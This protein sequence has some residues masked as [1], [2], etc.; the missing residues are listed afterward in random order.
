[1]ANVQI[2]IPAFDE[3]KQV[4]FEIVGKTPLMM[5]NPAS[6]LKPVGPKPVQQRIPKAEDEAAAAAYKNDDGTFYFPADAFR[7]AIVKAGKG[8]KA[9]RAGVAGLAMAGVFPVDEHVQL[10]D[11]ETGKPLR[12]YEIDV[13]RAVPPG[14]GAVSRARPKLP[15]WKCTLRVEVNESFLPVNV[16]L[17]LLQRAG[18]IIGIGDY[19]PERAGRFGKFRANLM[20]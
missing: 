7:S 8:L 2:E 12:K 19:R 9:G 10:L 13:R 5:H 14:Q 16:V 6:M 18:E 3:K 1:M 17:A 4:M 15:Y 11:E 20:E